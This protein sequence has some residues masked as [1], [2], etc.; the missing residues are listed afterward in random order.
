MSE[1]GIHKLSIYLLDIINLYHGLDLK[2][3]GR[4]NFHGYSI[5][6]VHTSTEQIF[7]KVMETEINVI[8]MDDVV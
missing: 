5:L 1:F 4:T 8:A 7:R 3:L 6:I 2:F